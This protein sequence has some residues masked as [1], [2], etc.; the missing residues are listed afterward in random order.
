[1]TTY[2]FSDGFYPRNELIHPGQVKTNP[3]SLL[4]PL[5]RLRQVVSQRYTTDED[6]TPLDIRKG[7]N[8]L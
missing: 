1:M 5:C 4:L 3:T 6:H 2:G 7:S 8:I